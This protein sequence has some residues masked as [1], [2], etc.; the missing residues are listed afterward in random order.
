MQKS[1]KLS[2][3]TQLS[4]SGQE[5]RLH[6]VRL[7]PPKEECPIPICPVWTNMV[8]CIS[9][10]LLVMLTLVL[11]ANK[12]SPA[13]WGVLP[14]HLGLQGGSHV[15]GPQHSRCVPGCSSRRHHGSL[16]AATWPTRQKGLPLPTAAPSTEVLPWRRGGSL[17]HVTSVRRLPHRYVTEPQ[18]VTSVMAWFL[19]TAV[20]PPSP[21]VLQEL[22]CG[23]S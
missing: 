8:Q 17:P 23:V 13:A 20:S 16:L 6:G 1:R 14:I 5:L 9:I 10:H 4:L 12:K 3:G 22:G 7:W 2:S 21:D 19:L 11:C 15:L 18:C